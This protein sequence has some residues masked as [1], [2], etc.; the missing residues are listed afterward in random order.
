MESVD[1]GLGASLGS[2]EGPL[3]ALQGSRTHA[4]GP[5]GLCWVFRGWHM[6]AP[7]G[8]R[9]A[10]LS[11]ESW[12]LAFPLRWISTGSKGRAAIPSLIA[13]EG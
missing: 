7:G 4:T 8:S 6:H 3:G 2:W 9:L 12:L 1:T 5:F 10:G 13:E 11:G